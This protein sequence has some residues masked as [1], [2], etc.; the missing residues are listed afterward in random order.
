MPRLALVAGGES[1]LLAGLGIAAVGDDAGV[2]AL[3]LV[4]Q[5]FRQLVEG[6]YGVVAL[7]G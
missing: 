7:A 5:V 2:V 6:A 3:D 4:G 1:V